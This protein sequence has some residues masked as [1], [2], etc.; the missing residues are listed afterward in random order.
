MYAI[1]SYY[2]LA[3]VKDNKIVIRRDW[4]K[5][6]DK[7]KGALVTWLASGPL[8]LGVGPAVTAGLWATIGHN[9]SIFLRFTGGRGL[10]AII[11][12]L[13][14]VFPW[15]A[16]FLLLV[17]FAGYLLHN[18][19]GSTVGLLGIPRITSYNVCYTKLLRLTPPH[20]NEILFL[21]ERLRQS[22]FV[23]AL[24]AFPSD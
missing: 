7:I 13:A 24:S 16:L 4:A 22:V 5:D 10:S 18:T 19:A 23:L 6:S 8:D 14:V 1:R 2:G 11:G 17:M 9:W 21:Q 3:K 12:T 20:T 15:G